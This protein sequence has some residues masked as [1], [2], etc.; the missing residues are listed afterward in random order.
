MLNQ[1]VLLDIVASGVMAPSADNN[2]IFKFDLENEA[3]NLRSSAEFAATHERH[4]RVLGMLSLGAVIENMSLRA[5][6]LGLKARVNYL[7]ATGDSVERLA[8]LTFEP[9]SPNVND[10]AP[11]IPI[12]HTNRRMYGG[13]ALTSSE[14]FALTQEVGLSN[15]V[16][17]LWLDGQKRKLV[18]GL[19]WRAES[20]RFLRRS[21]HSE[22]YSSIRFDLPW[23][24]TAECALPPGALEIEAPMR[25]LF[26]ALRHWALMRPLTWL[27]V[28][29][30]I[31]ARAGWFPCWQAPTLAVLTTSLSAEDGALE[32][33]RVFE[34]I[35]LRSTLL[36]LAL[37]PLAASAVL[38][39]Q[40]DSD[41]GASEALRTAL[42][43]GWRSVIPDAIPMMVF[44]IGR[45]AAPK[46]K[47][48]RQATEYYLAADR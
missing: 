22:I 32:V 34:R 46:I 35:W 44:R 40:S 9:G 5:N 6:E 10:L 27:G 23:T 7:P 41:G 24:S 15:S 33:G 31:G 11:A 17:L 20:E 29:Y 37:Q 2:H 36:G 8:R 14:T 38:P 47:S 28:H 48:S 19:V 16:K 4:R 12:R 43:S 30:L 21:L 13:P 26:K 42:S 3:I 25:P 18:H 39:L 45:A 1:K